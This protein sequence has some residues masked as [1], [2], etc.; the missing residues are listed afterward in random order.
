MDTESPPLNFFTRHQAKAPRIFIIASPLQNR[1][2]PKITFTTIK[3]LWVIDNMYVSKM[4]VSLGIKND[5]HQQNLWFALERCFYE[6]AFLWFETI[7]CE[8]FS[9]INWN[10]IDFRAFSTENILTTLEFF[11]IPPTKASLP[12]I[13]DLRSWES[14]AVAVARVKIN[15]KS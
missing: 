9:E 5:I 8:T 7:M 12:C 4:Y 2:P 10:Y 14:Y 1:S 11:H 6:R 15:S 3:I 13:L